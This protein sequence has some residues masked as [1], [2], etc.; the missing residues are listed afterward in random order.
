MDE[1]EK[2]NKTRRPGERLKSNEVKIEIIEY[3]ISRNNVITGPDIRN[4]LREKFRMKDRKNIEDHLKELQKKRCIEK[5]EKNGFENR[6]DITK[7]EHL[8]NIK[9]NFINIQL[10]KYEKAIN[11]LLQKN[12]YR[13]TDLGGFFAYI[14]LLLSDSFFNTCLDTSIST[15]ISRSFTI[16]EFNNA[17]YWRY[18]TKK[19]NEYYIAYTKRYPNIDISYEDFVHILTE[20]SVEHNVINSYEMFTEVWKE[21]IRKFVKEQSNKIEDDQSIYTSIYEVFKMTNILMENF[22]DV[23]FLVLFES[24]F[25]QD[26]LLNKA[27]EE[28]KIYAIETKANSDD[29]SEALKSKNDKRKSLKKLILSD[30]EQASFIMKLYKQ[31]SNFDKKIYD[32]KEELLK[33]LEAYFEEQFQYFGSN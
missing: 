15:L 27:S 25:I 9:E 16:Y 28:E 31:P 30:L 1:E 19:T 14:W 29:Y 22:Q 20:V 23:L 32:D 3:I 7:I 24:Y 10:N 5:F 8:K 33:S 12:G 18:T 17:G 2:T 26:V 13:V 4:H 6:W 21:N 11:I